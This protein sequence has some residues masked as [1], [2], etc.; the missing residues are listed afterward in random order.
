MKSVREARKEQ[1][2]QLASKRESGSDE[3]ERRCGR[4]VELEADVPLPAPRRKRVPEYKRCVS[5][6][7]RDVANMW[8]EGRREGEGE[9][10]K[11]RRGGRNKAL[12]F[13]CF[14]RMLMLRPVPD[15]FLEIRDETA[16]MTLS[17]R[18]DDEHSGRKGKARE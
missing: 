1:V 17:I 4:R 3:S 6:T 11:G 5:A 10:E 2:S 12:T 15:L 16:R 9:R 13:D 18:Y 7:F 8:K 14:F